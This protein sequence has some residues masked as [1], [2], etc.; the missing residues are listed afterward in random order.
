MQHDSNCRGFS[1]LIG[2]RKEAL[3]CC[4]KS[5][6]KNQD[7]LGF[8]S[9]WS[10]LIRDIASCMG[11]SCYSYT[12]LMI[13]QLL[14]SWCHLFSAEHTAH[15]GVVQCKD[16]HKSNSLSNAMLCQLQA[17]YI[18]ERQ[19]ALQ[20]P[21]SHLPRKYP[22]NLE[23]LFFVFHYYLDYFEFG[24]EKNQAETFIKH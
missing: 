16:L 1:L 11:F 6:R 9:T 14:G 2:C 21:G 12:L 19:L 7:Q 24:T 3:L 15:V 22:E 13:H 8:L 18:F 5:S 20:P 10:G 23:D 17:T 4:L